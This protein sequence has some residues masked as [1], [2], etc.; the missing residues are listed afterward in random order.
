M[1][2]AELRT[3]MKAISSVT[4]GRHGDAGT[5]LPKTGTQGEE[6]RQETSGAGPCQPEL[7]LGYHSGYSP[8][9]LAGRLEE[10]AFT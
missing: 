10:F 1:G 8:H 6:D 2:G 9:K 5:H 4:C 3:Q 7:A